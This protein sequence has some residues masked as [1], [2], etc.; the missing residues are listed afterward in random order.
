MKYR[1]GRGR[2]QERKKERKG[3]REIERQTEEREEQE[4]R[5]EHEGRNIV[6]SGKCWGYV[7]RTSFSSTR[8]SPFSRQAL[9]IKDS[10]SVPLA[11]LLVFTRSI[12]SS[13]F[14]SDE[15]LRD[16]NAEKND[17]YSGRD[18]AL[19]ENGKIQSEV[20]FRARTIVHRIVTLRS[21]QHHGP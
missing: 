13:P 3:E 12:R 1:K 21:A 11:L 2:E 17:D 10:L 6:A 16:A 4:R 5:I 8:F 18:F 19:P 14:A 9:P 7:A 15:F 20:P